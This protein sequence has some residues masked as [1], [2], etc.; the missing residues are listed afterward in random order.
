MNRELRRQTRRVA[1]LMLSLALAGPI[2]PTAVITRAAAQTAGAARAKERGWEAYRANDFRTALSRAE[3]A[4]ASGTLATPELAD[5][6]KLKG[7]CLTDLNRNE[8]AI[9]AF[10]S[11]LRLDPSI[12]VDGEEYIPE[13]IQNFREAKARLARPA[14]VPRP[15]G[16]DTAGR[17]SPGWKRWYVIGP[18]VAI[19]GI[20]A[21]TALGG[22]GGNT[23]DED[24]PGFPEP[25]R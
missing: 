6:W 2:A 25:P 18:A 3:E 17:R 7:L 9:S 21:A 24:L 20:V 15:A 10:E 8:E 16:V 14:P 1:A 19:L 5:A 11:A 23:G 12:T 4:I 22:G 13:E